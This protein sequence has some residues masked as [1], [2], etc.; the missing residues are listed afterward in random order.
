MRLAVDRLDSG[1]AIPIEPGRSDFP[2]RL[3]QAVALQ[4]KATLFS[5]E[6]RKSRNTIRPTLIFDGMAGR[7]TS[8]STCPCR[9]NQGPIDFFF[10]C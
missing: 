4:R 2:P 6:H 5:T 3:V 8:L 9:P 1:T 10:F 7:T